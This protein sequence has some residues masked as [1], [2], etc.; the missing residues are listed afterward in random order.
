MNDLNSF[1][2]LLRRCVDDYGMI[3]AGDGIA[4]GVSGGKDSLVLL[5]GL[6][7]LQTYYPAPFRLE[8]VTI[9]LG[10]LLLLSF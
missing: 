1:S 10:F 2:G 6:R 5:R 4:V 9:D 7:H 8:A 3:S